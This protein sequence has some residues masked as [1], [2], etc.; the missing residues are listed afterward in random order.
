[1]IT[2]TIETYLLGQNSMYAELPKAIAE[3]FRT[4]Y[5]VAPSMQVLVNVETY[6]TGNENGHTI[7]VIVHSVATPRIFE[8]VEGD[9]NACALA[10]ALYK[11]LITRTAAS[12]RT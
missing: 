3:E 6:L 12:V 9:S 10:L 4:F 2:R 5:R 7:R 11:K 1:M 8:A